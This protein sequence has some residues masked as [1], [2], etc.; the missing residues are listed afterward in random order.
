[1]NFKEYLTENT[2]KVI[3]FD[4]DNTLANTRR[5]EDGDY[6]TDE[7]GNLYVDGSN[8]QIIDLLWQYHQQGYKIWIVTARMATHTA[9]KQVE[10]FVKQHDLPV[11]KMYFTNYRKKGP[12]M[13]KLQHVV[14]KHYDDSQYEIDSIK[15]HAP[16]IEAILVETR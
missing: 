2:Q 3:S 11:E 13:A 8:A 5:T 16:K 1:M 9:K 14:A 6:A 4:F 12:L 10:D 15:Q 7:Q